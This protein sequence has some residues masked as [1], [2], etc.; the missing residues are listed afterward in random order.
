LNETTQARTE[1]PLVLAADDE[2]TV[3][4]MLKTGLKDAGFQVALASGG[5][6][7]LRMLENLSPDVIL[8]DVMM[9]DMSGVEVARAIRQTST[10]PIIML[11]AL[12]SEQDIISGLD[13]GADDY[14]VKPFR[15]GELT[16]RIRAA[17]RRNEGL[18]AGAA[19][20][21]PGII[22]LGKVILDRDKR[23]LINESGQAVNLSAME[24]RLL[25]YMVNNR[26]RLLTHAEL[27]EQLWG[28]GHEERAR[29]LRVYIRAIRHKLGDTGRKP[30]FLHSH[31]S[32]GYVFDLPS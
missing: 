14:L 32:E 1:E 26:G 24:Y 13:A 27:A 11:T 5:T 23:E 8:L 15:L 20:E 28:P 19:Q 10:V 16:A 29:Y 7:A 22:R 3:R 12:G 2:L 4:T 9:P 30:R 31:Y 25:N 21:K 17:I 6:E 18:T